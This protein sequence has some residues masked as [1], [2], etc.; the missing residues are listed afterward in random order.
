MT[1]SCFGTDYDDD[2]DVEVD[3]DED[4]DDD[5]VDDYDYDYY[6]WLFTVTLSQRSAIANLR[7]GH[8]RDVTLDPLFAE[9]RTQA[10]V[11]WLRR[12]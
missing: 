6:C 2:E 11:L 1:K 9:L 10:T 4:G 12:I 3:D 5:D 8:K 7:H